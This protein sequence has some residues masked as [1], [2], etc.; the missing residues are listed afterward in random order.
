MT[1]AISVIIPV[2]PGESHWQHLLEDLEPF[3][4][5]L[6][7]ILVSAEE[8]VADV[9]WVKS[10]GGRAASLNAGAAVAKSDHLW[11]LH[12]DSRL[13]KNAIAK[14][15]DCIQEN[16]QALYFYNLRFFDGKKIMKLTEL[17]T[18]WRSQILKIPFGDQGFCLSKK[19]FHDIGP[20]DEGAPYGEDHLLVWQAHRKNIPVIS[21]GEV[22][23]TSA[24]KYVEKG[25]LYVTLQHQFL[26]LKQAIPGLR[27]CVWQKSH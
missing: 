18:W 6:E 26:W 27:R 2:A 16:P 11:F 10:P 8:V 22:I 24:R 13:E 15:L 14:L 25:W 1:A 21:V 3:K 5:Q 19:T 17:G 7:I 12:A 4:D 9:I 20:F 23:A